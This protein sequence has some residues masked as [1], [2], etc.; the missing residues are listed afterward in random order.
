MAVLLALTVLGAKLTVELRSVS[1]KRA[2]DNRR[3]DTVGIEGGCERLRRD[4][5][6]SRNQKLVLD[7]PDFRVHIGLV[8][9]DLRQNG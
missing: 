6:T 5:A 7:V 8:Q 2:G 4:G 9:V 3:R 1:G